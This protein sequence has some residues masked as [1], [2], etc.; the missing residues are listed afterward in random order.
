VNNSEGNN[1]VETNEMELIHAPAAL[2]ERHTWIVAVYDTALAY[3]G[4][5]EGGW[6][7]DTGSLV[8]IVFA[9]PSEDAAYSYSRKLNNRLRSRVFGPNQ[10]R[11]DKSS[12]LSD[13]FFEACVYQDHAP[14]GYPDVRPHYE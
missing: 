10:G 14:K 11:R 8:R 4:P 2:R 6:W 1:K 13:G 12:V 9:T 7:Y 5:E 3:G